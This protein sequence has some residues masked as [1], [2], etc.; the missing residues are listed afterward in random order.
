MGVSTED[1]AAVLLR[2]VRDGVADVPGVVVVAA[3]YADAR[4]VADAPLAP[5]LLPRVAR[6]AGV[7][8]AA[9]HRDQGRPRPAAV[10]LARRARIAGGRSP[11]CGFQMA[12]AGALRAR[13]TCRWSA[14]PGPTSPASA[15]PRVAARPALGTSR[16]SACP[17]PGRGV[18]RFADAVAGLILQLRWVGR[19]GTGRAAGQAVPGDPSSIAVAGRQSGSRPDSSIYATAGASM[20]P[21]TSSRANGATFW[22]SRA[23]ATGTASPRLRRPPR[24][25]PACSR[26]LSRGLRLDQA[27]QAEADVP[28]LV[29]L[30]AR[31]PRTRGAARHR[32]S[33]RSVCAL[34]EDTPSSGMW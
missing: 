31:T 2:T 6:A 18:C 33:S 22:R 9:G 5:Q 14:R 23:S 24:P 1:E 15:R 10:A 8:S 19:M 21:E 29:E 16:H 17:C 3:A 27:A 30:D 28:A 4:R 34:V 20:S 11:W 12:L 26:A 13:R 32:P 7:G 25:A